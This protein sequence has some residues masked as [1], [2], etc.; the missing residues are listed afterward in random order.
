MK[1]RLLQDALLDPEDLDAQLAIMLC[2]K[3][4]LSIHEFLV[5]VVLH[6]PLQCLGSVRHALPERRDFRDLIKLTLDIP[7]FLMNAVGQTLH[8]GKVTILE[9]LGL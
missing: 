5:H 2:E 7:G 9:I 8:S 4:A 1:T 6:M 3:R